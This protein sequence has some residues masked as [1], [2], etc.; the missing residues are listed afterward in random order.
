MV[1][2]EVIK[3]IH[4][5]SLQQRIN[6]K[7]NEDNRYVLLHVVPEVSGGGSTYTRFSAIFQA[8]PPPTEAEAGFIPVVDVVQN[9]GTPVARALPNPVIA[10]REHGGARKSRNKRGKK[11]RTSKKR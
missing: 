8:P 4:P 9:R 5:D 7:L 2:V 3:N 10:I 6:D 11:R 1:Q